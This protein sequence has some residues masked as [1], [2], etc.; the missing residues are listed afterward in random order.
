[1]KGFSSQLENSAKQFRMIQKRL[2]IRF[3]S[4]GASP[5]NFLDDLLKETYNSLLNTSSNMEKSLQYLQ[6]LLHEIDCS[7]RLIVLLAKYRFNLDDA[8]TGILFRYLCPVITDNVANAYE[9]ILDSG[10]THLLRTSLAKSGREK[11]NIAQPLSEVTNIKKV[12]KH[13]QI[14]NLIFYQSY[15]R[16]S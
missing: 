16:S 4:N 5:L 2:L 1:M 12:F 14:V 9:E 11:A 6:D 10:L 15:L 7:S 3:T 13:I 8:N